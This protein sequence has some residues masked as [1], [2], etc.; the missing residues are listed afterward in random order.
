M[1]E[2][3]FNQALAKGDVQVAQ[4]PAT[5]SQDDEPES[6]FLYGFI[7]ILQ[8][9]RSPATVLT[10]APTFTPKTFLDEIQ[11]YD[12]GTTKAVYLYINKT[13]QVFPA[14]SPI[15]EFDNGS[16]SGT[17]T[18]DWSNGIHQYVTLTGNTTFTFTNPKSGMHSF[19]HVAGAFTPT[20]PGTVRWTAGTT[21]TATATSGHKDIY[22]FIYSPKESLYDGLQSPNY[23]IT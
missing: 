15:A 12:D 18:I 1:T 8:Q 4:A 19:L 22:T 16:V 9:L 20:F 10:T 7:A 23:A 5:Q 2:A 17:K 6:N 11:F 13:W 14:P 21:P 3:E